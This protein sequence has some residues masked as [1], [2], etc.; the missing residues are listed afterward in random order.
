[1][2]SR[3]SPVLAPR[4]S[5][6]WLASYPRSGNTLLRLV[7]KHCFGLYSQSIYKDQ[8][9]ADAQVRDAVGHEE[10]GTNPH[11]FIDRARRTGRCLFVKTHEPPSTDQHPAIYVVRDG[12]AAVVSYAH[13]LRDVL[14]REVSIT[15]LIEGRVGPSWSQHVKS[16]ILPLRANTLVVRYEDLVESNLETLEAIENF[17]GHKLLRNFDNRFEF[18][19]ALH[20]TF[21]RRGSN[22]ANIAEMDATCRKLFE[23]YH[24]DTLGALGY[25]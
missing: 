14:H 11:L 17:I 20:P 16:W 18:F 22:E 19:N 13:Y 25:K 23:A 9:F 24:G 1:M 21:F 8:D 4:S 5:L 6:T 12:R 2:S 15:A 7:L 10:V 3:I